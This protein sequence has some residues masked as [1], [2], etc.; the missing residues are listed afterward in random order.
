MN[1]ITERLAAAFTLAAVLVLMAAPAAMATE[2][3][4]APDTG[5]VTEEF[6]GPPPAV[7]IDET[8]AAEDD[9]AWTFRYLVPTLLA[10]TIAV[11]GIVL[12]VYAL[13]IRGRYRVVS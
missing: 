4:A 8:A 6:S 1:R 7:V 3:P 10:L 13:R 2:E 12:I 5:S 9:P 11:I